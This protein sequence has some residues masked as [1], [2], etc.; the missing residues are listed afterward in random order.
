[1]WFPS[2]DAKKYLT[3][4][5]N[6]PACGNEQ[7]WEIEMSDASRVPEFLDIYGRGGLS[8]EYRRALASLIIASFEDSI[9]EG[10]F[11]ER[12]WKMF[13]EMIREHLDEIEGVLA[14]W[15]QVEGDGYAITIRL[16]DIV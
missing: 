13:S 10:K 14:P 16:R 3:A 4:T 9:W 1:M 6:L 8:G 2:E 12:H 7:D 11:S 5:L 15:T